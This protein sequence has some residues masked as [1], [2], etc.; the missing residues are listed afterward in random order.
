MSGTIEERTLESGPNRSVLLEAASSAPGGARRIVKR[1]HARGLFA[2]L[3]DPRR[4]RR[5]L[6]VH[7]ALFA[8]GLRVPEPLG[9]RRSPSGPE[10]LSAFV[11]SAPSLAE[12]VAGR[13]PWPR[14]P[15][16]LARAL[17]RLLARAQR[18]GLDSPD[19]HAGNVLVDPRGEP[20]LIDFGKARLRRRLSERRSRRDLVVLAAGLRE[21]LPF[22]FRAR[23]LLAWLAEHGRARAG[24]A[25]LGR[26]IE[27][28]ARVRR[29]AIA[30]R[31]AARWLRAS[32]VAR[33][34]R[35]LGEELL[36]RRELPA[37][38]LPA[39]LA[40]LGGLGTARD[41]R[42][43]DRS[44]LIDQRAEGGP[45]TLLLSGAAELVASWS[46]MGRAHD[47]RLPCAR[48][49]CLVRSRPARAAFELPFGAR[50]FARA[51]ARSLPPELAR[52][53]GALAGALHDRGLD[54]GGERELFVTGEGGLLLGPRA[55]LARAAGDAR[56]RAAPWLA[57]GVARES[58]VRA[59]VAEL[60]GGPSE[61]ERV[62]RELARG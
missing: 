11:P 37:G 58:F 17:G 34:E 55:R 4:A 28:R 10:L 15:E 32:G 53:A 21:E 22:G 12:I 52:G 38:E 35:V 24:R 23:F 26:W 45:R 46:A 27:G 8:A 62:A 31:N 6:R 30:E 59:F 16:E 7:S 29:V 57:L 1:F 47:Q 51:G 41:P 48:P 19:L 56:S 54:L 3:A 39:L 2:R 40:L 49:L 33:L 5:E 60:R 43:P 13:A 36:V 44:A 14:P 42:W 20:W 25:E 61:R 50:P 18:A 9:L